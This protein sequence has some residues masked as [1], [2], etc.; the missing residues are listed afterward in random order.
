MRIFLCREF[1]W[2]CRKQH[3]QRIRIRTNMSSI[4]ASAQIVAHDIGTRNNT[5]RCRVILAVEF[6]HIKS[7]FIY[8]IYVKE[9]SQK[10]CIICL[11]YV[12][13][14]PIYVYPFGYTI[15]DLIVRFLCCLISK[16]NPKSIHQTSYA[17]LI[18]ST[19]T[20]CV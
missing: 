10:K 18:Q 19:E 14:I 11:K 13:D 2:F 1:Q 4:A 6:E 16:K 9:F 15:H 12:Y 20:F 7:V 3:T 8:N 5:R 17:F